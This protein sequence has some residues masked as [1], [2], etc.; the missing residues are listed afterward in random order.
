MPAATGLLGINPISDE[1]TA[2]RTCKFSDDP[3]RRLDEKITA[4]G[5]HQLKLNTTK[6]MN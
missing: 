1:S 3:S 2:S 6:A 4:C 5:C